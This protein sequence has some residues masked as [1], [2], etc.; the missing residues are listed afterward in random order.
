M[1][2]FDYPR[3]LAYGARLTQCMQH[4]FALVIDTLEIMYMTEKGN[5]HVFHLI[6]PHEA[7]KAKRLAIHPPNHD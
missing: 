4:R 3:P 1:W 6:T 5:L 2:N 7:A